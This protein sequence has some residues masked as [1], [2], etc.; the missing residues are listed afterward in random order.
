MKLFPFPTKPRPKLRLTLLWKNTNTPPSYKDW[1]DLLA[2]FTKL[3]GTLGDDTC[4]DLLLNPSWQSEGS[5]V[6]KGILYPLPH[7]SGQKVLCTIL[8]CEQQVYCLSVVCLSL[9]LR[10]HRKVPLYLLQTLSLMKGKAGATW[11]KYYPNSELVLYF[12]PKGYWGTCA[13]GH[14]HCFLSYF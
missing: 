12:H 13:S 14:E 8:P 4:T 6:Y 10:S 9:S 7:C 3:Q 5:L 1:P 2:C 11:R